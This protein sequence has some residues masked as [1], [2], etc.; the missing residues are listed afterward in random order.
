MKSKSLIILFY[1]SCYIVGQ[2]QNFQ[3]N[4]QNCY[5]GSQSDIPYDMAV[6]DG[7]YLIVGGTSSADGDVTYNHGNTDVW[8]MK[9]DFEGNLLWEK[10]IG[11]SNAEYCSQIINP[12]DNSYYLLC[13]TLSSD[14]D[15]SFDPYPES[16]DFWIVKIDDEGNIIWDKIVGGNAGDDVWAGSLTNDG[17]IVMIGTTYSNDGDVSISYGGPD[18]WIVK[19]SSESILEWDFTIG[20]DWIDKG[21]AII[22]TSDGGYLAESS[23][24]L[25]EG[26][27][28]NIFSTPHSYGWTDG[29]IFKLDSNLQVEWQKC[30]GGSDHDGIFGMLEIEDGYILT[31]STSSNDGDVSG[32]YGASDSWI[33]KIDFNGNI[34]WQNPLGGSYGESGSIIIQN[35]SGSFYSIVNTY[36]NNG[37]VSG[38]HSISIFDS[39][40]WLVKLNNDGELTSQQCIGGIRTDCIEFGVIK[41]SEH[42]FV[43]AAQTN[44][45]PSYDVQCDPHGVYPDNDFWVLEISDSTT[46]IVEP[47]FNNDLINIYPNPAKDYMILETKEHNQLDHS[48]ILIRDIYGN[49]ITTVMLNSNQTVWDTRSIAPGIYFYRTVIDGEVVSGKI[50]FKK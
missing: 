34:I 23:S 39:D 24:I 8:L 15:I 18:S 1:I 9:I 31:G 48:E 35:S 49:Q 3:I 4:W 19:L 2:S 29:V 50:I 16:T 43:L 22:A 26:G 13:T 12:L 46:G 11:G 38:N 25:L 41:K 42:T 27:Y 6:V 30:Y 10:T 5:G 14:G 7:G 44:F 21:Q 45:G 33:L 36:S 17:G 32:W 40:L 20:T 37:D 28:G 47:A